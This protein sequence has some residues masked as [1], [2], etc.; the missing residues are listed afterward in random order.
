MTGGILNIILGPNFYICSGLQGCGGAAI[1]TTLSQC[2]SLIILI[3]F[4]NKKSI[5]LTVKN[6][7]INF[8]I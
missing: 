6:L 8:I 5:P 1:A 7:K 4:T 2:R 3:I